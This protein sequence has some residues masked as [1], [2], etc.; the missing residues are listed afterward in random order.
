MVFSQGAGALLQRRTDSSPPAEVHPDHRPPAAAP[1]ILAAEGVA[2]Q[3]NI[4]KAHYPQ[5]GLPTERTPKQTLYHELAA[6]SVLVPNHAVPVAHLLPYEQNTSS[7]NGPM[8]AEG[9]HL[10]FVP[11]CL[12]S[13]A[14][15]GCAGRRSSSTS[16]ISSTSNSFQKPSRS[17]SSGGGSSLRWQPAAVYVNESSTPPHVMTRRRVL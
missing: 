17:R 9:V 15:S 10:C 6:P 7:S 16:K 12:R 4:G 13:S 11:W 14:L 8:F 2:V 1:I 5:S 3:T